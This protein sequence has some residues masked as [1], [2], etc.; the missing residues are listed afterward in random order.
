MHMQACNGLLHGARAD[1][2]VDHDTVRA[3]VDQVMGDLAMVNHAQDSL[4][5]HVTST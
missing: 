3:V 2:A 1:L 5:L 4:A